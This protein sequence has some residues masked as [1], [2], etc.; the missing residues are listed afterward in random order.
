[1]VLPF[2][3]SVANDGLAPLLRPPLATEGFRGICADAPFGCSRR[4]SCGFACLSRRNS[5]TDEIDGSKSL[6]AWLTD[7][8]QPPAAVDLLSGYPV[9]VPGSG[10]SVECTAVVFNG[11]VDDP[12]QPF[13]PPQIFSCCSQ[14]MR[15]SPGSHA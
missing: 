14:A 15:C 1:M 6:I 13:P 8:P 7:A 10:D 9:V 12:V 2:L 11:L 4:Q 5:H 3:C